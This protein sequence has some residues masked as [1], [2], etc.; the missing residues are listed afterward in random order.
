LASCS[1][2][3]ER[4]TVGRLSYIP[5]IVKLQESPGIAGGLLRRIYSDQKD[6]I[7]SVIKAAISS[8]ISRLEIGLEKTNRRIE[9]FENEYSISSDVFLQNYAAEDLKND[10]EG[11][12]RWAGEL[13]LRE[14]MME[15]LNNPRDIEYVAS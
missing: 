6:R 5:G 13:K 11:Y 12:I 14:R 2:N 3:F 8:E 15:D 7:I 9:N 1:V 4:F 10:D